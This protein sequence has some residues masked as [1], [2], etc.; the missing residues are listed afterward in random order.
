MLGIVSGAIYLFLSLN[1]AAR[2]P[3]G[4]RSRVGIDVPLWLRPSIFSLRLPVCL[5]S[6][7]PSR[8]LSLFLYL[9]LRLCPSSLSPRCYH[10]HPFCYYAPFSVAT[11][12]FDFPK[13]PA[14]CQTFDYWVARNVLA[15]GS[16]FFFSISLSLFPFIFCSRGSSFA[17]FL[18]PREF[19]ATGRVDS[20]SR[21]H[22]KHRRHIVVPRST[23]C[24]ID[25]PGESSKLCAA[26]LR[27]C[28]YPVPSRYAALRRLPR[29]RTLGC[30]NFWL[31]SRSRVT[32]RLLGAHFSR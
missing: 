27:N 5:F 4:N 31:F 21:P 6:V 1:N 24:R 13:L 26:T 2:S 29:G 9:S 22:G 11:F 15:V 7:F 18:S 25:G 3:G 12:H 30:R 23:D 8:T 20:A 10:A 16:F 17:R 19:T 28:S 14:R 32:A